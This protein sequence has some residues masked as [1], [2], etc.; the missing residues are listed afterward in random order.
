MKIDQIHDS[1]TACK[2]AGSQIY[3]Q[4]TRHS[5]IIIVVSRVLRELTGWD[6]AHLWIL[7]EGKGHLSWERVMTFVC[8]YFG[9]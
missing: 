5:G 4:R 3:P 8:L 6:G 9:P 7:L 1:D 2:V